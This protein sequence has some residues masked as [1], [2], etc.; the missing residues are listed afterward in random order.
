MF[1]SYPDKARG[2]APWGLA[3]IILI[4]L[5]VNLPNAG[6]FF[7]QDDFA[8]MNVDA[9]N[10]G[11]FARF[12]APD[13]YGLR[14]WYRPVSFDI[15]FWLMREI[16]GFNPL[17]HH[18]LPILLHCLNIFLCYFFLNRLTRRVDLPL[19]ASAL[20]GLC[21]AHQIALY[22]VSAGVEPITAFF[23]LLGL[24]AYLSWRMNPSFAGSVGIVLLFIIILLCK[25][26]AL[27]FPFALLLT[28]AFFPAAGN[29]VKRKVTGR[30]V[31]LYIWLFIILI[32]YLIFWFHTQYQPGIG[33]EHG[34]GLTTNPLTITANLVA[35]IVQLF[36]GNAIIYSAVQGY[37]IESPREFATGFLSSPTGI[38]LGLIGLAVLIV[39]VVLVRRH[40]A[41]FY[42][43]ERRATGW[44]LLWLIIC[45][46]PVLPMPGHNTAYYL[47]IPMIG[48]S[49][50]LAGLALGLGHTV[51]RK[52]LWHTIGW[53]LFALYV[54]N[55]AVNI[56]LGARVTPL[57]R[58][59]D[60][61]RHAFEQMKELH[62]SFEPGTLLFIID[63]DDELRWTL[64]DGLMY[65]S[66]YDEQLRWC[67]TI[68]KG[69]RFGWGY[70]LV[71]GWE[72][73]GRRIYYSYDGHEFTPRDEEYFMREYP[74][75][76]D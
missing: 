57:A 26:S 56:S 65:K 47:N 67:F 64:N 40:F 48:F 36:V 35:Y 52:K 28:D 58:R 68:M 20:Y 61:G 76:G 71:H 3:A 59:S 41:G 31:S 49:A 10:F 13:P 55:F 9:D 69:Q 27:T 21:G 15:K 63:I 19:L 24:N 73:G 25:E 74:P 45:L 34:Y 60:A 44:G 50:C 70:L 62:T 46:L 16:F 11:E 37:S 66:Y 32:A 54:A 75:D 7:S 38:T 51:K 39:A 30:K 43:H 18:L 14:A 2:F 53:L 23:Y 5:A 72:E 4:V 42:P 12:F 17:P 33:E 1:T 22:W 29:K 8:G 6:D